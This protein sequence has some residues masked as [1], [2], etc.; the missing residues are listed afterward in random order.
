[1]TGQGI[2]AELIRQRFAKACAR[3]GLGKR[4]RGLRTDLFEPP[5]TGAGQ[6]DLFGS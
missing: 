3:L 2:F 4:D 1:M 5:R 6:L